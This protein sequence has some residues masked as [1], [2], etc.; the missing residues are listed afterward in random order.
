MKHRSLI[1]AMLGGHLAMPAAAQCP[2][3]ASESRVGFV[4]TLELEHADGRIER[5][6]PVHNLIPVEGIAHMLGVTFKSAVQVPTWYI[7]LYEGDYNPLATTTAATF[8]AQ[9]TECTAY[10][11]GTR[12]A[13]VS[14][15]VVAGALDNAATRAEYTFTANKTVHG[16]AL[17][18]SNVKGGGGGLCMSLVR[19][20]TP[21]VCETGS[22]LR[23]V[24]GAGFTSI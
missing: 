6:P 10:S 4:Y 18:S 16:G 5:D 17:L 9:A 8:A 3:M 12:P 1:S 21:K 22:T 2:P 14:G 20:P 13:F 11:A 15:A 24:A 7:A 23:I 19:F